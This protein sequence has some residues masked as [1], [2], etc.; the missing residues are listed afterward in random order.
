MQ[1]SKRGDLYVR[2]NIQ[3]PKNLTHEQREL[4]EKLA[5]TGI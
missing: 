1:G 5:E 4:I 3:V 2:L